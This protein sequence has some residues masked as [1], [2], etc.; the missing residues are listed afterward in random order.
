VELASDADLANVG[1][2]FDAELQQGNE[3]YEARKKIR[4]LLLDTEGTK[5]S[6][7]RLADYRNYYRFDVEMKDVNGRNTALLSQRIGKGSGG[8]HQAP[9]YVAIG[10]ALAATYRI[11]RDVDGNVRAGMTL[12][13]FDEAFSK[14]DIQNCANAME[15]MRDL[16]MQVVVAA[17]NEKFTTLAEE[18]DTMV[19]V[20]RDGAAVSVTPQY[21]KQAARDALAADNPYKRPSLSLVVNSEIREAGNE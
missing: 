4:E 9:F 20:Y 2:L 6:E 17:P 7:E 21:I 19:H 11:E 3:H 8:E 16:G 10:A 12:A 1:S 13:L 15:F 18:M 14:L 5:G